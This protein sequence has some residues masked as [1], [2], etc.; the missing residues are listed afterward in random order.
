MAIDYDEFYELIKDRYG[1]T[2]LVDLLDIKMDDLV[3]CLWE[4]IQD[5]IYI[6]EEEYPDFF[7]EEENDISSM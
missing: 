1:P 5:N 3:S 6:F 4:Y 2:D 7:D